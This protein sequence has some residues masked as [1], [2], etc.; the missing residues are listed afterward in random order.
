[1]IPESY[2]PHMLSVS[3]ELTGAGHDGRSGAGQGG[4]CKAAP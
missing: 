4:F 2:L 1:M 3:G